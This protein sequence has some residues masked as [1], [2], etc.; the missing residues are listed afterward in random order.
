MVLHPISRL[1]IWAAK[2]EP[3]K[4]LEVKVEREKGQVVCTV[5]VDEEV[6]SRVSERY[7]GKS[8]RS[9]V[10]FAAADQAIRKLGV[11]EQE[12]PEDVDEVGWPEEVPDYEW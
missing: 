7:R 11:I 5:I 4:K 6:I 1:A 8:T 3:Q 12:T 9:G 2:Q 10:R